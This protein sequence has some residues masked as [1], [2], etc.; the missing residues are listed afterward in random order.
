MAIASPG[1]ELHT[2]IER[3]SNVSSGHISLFLPDLFKNILKESYPVLP[4]WDG[5]GHYAPTKLLSVEKYHQWKVRC[6]LPRYLLGTSMIL[7]EINQQYLTADQLTAANA[8]Q[9]VIKESVGVLEPQLI[10]QLE[11]Q[12]PPSAGPRS[13]QD[14]GSAVPH[15]AFVPPPALHQV[16]PERRRREVSPAAGSA[17]QQAGPVGR[18]RKRPAS[19]HGEEDVRPPPSQ[20]HRTDPNMRYICDVCGRGFARSDDLRDHKISAHKIGDPWKCEECDKIY[21]RKKGLEEHYKTKHAG[22]YLQ[23]CPV[24]NC[25]YKCQSKKVLDSHL[26]RQHGESDQTFACPKCKKNFASEYLRDRHVT[27]NMCQ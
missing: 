26:A 24:L 19:V 11:R 8:L 23:H 17:E 2:R 1:P 15:L 18:G 4:A 27:K 16:Q 22:V 25:E 14:P 12:N 7:K 6:Q 21:G 9:D 3:A 10:T 5:S 13:S 20:V